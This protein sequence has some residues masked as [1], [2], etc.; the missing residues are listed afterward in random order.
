[1]AGNG[2]GSPQVLIE[3]SGDDEGL[4]TI[5]LTFTVKFMLKSSNP[6]GRVN[7]GL[8]RVARIVVSVLTALPMYP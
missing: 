4:I 1:M 6:H 2:T 5:Q 8:I 7:D 3:H